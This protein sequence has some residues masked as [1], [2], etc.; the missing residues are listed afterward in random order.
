MGKHTRTDFTNFQN[1]NH[2]HPDPRGLNQDQTQSA[3]NIMFC[4][5]KV[6]AEKVES[7]CSCFCDLAFFH[8]FREQQLRLKIVSILT[9]YL[10]FHVFDR[11]NMFFGCDFL[12]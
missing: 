1:F 2:K 5:E 3:N 9:V 10:F 7:I 6:M 8:N 11:I 12:K 4:I